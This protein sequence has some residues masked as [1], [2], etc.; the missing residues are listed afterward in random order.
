MFWYEK[1]E[2]FK[3]SLFQE[4]TSVAP[5]P[6]D[7]LVFTNGGLYS[8]SKNTGLYPRLDDIHQTITELKEEMH[9]EC[10]KHEKSA[11]GQ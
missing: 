8:L 4:L 1:V 9:L 5:G 3:N 11:N 6:G 2:E 7:A 10:L